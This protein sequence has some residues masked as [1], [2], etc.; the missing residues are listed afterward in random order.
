LEEVVGSAIKEMSASLQLHH[1]SV[2]LPDDLPLLQFDAV[3]IERVL[4]NLLDNE[5]KYTPSGS[6]IEISAAPSANDMIEVR[7]EDN[8]PGLP[9][10]REEEI[11][12][13]F[14]RGQKESATPGVGLG[15]TI[16][17]AI[18]EAHG[19]AIRAET[20]AEG[21]ARFIFSL[22]CGIPPALNIAEDNLANEHE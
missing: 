13:K 21:G 1:V 5:I 10:G 7:V 12:K 22:P 20:R 2:K 8:G 3:L 16:C 19:G 11:F 6:L 15:L 18:V 9:A 17:R 4:V 14:E